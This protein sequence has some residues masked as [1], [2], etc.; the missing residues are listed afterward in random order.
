LNSDSLTSADKWD[1]RYREASGPGNPAPILAEHLHLLPAGGNALD[2]ACGLG[3]NTLLLAQHGLSTQGWD[4]SAVALQRLNERAA[5][6]GLTVTTRQRDVEADPPPPRSF[7]LIVVTDFL[8]RPICPAISAALR[9]GGLLFYSTWCAGKRSASGP[10]NPEFL[11]Q[12][13]EL[14]RLFPSLHVRFYREDAAAGT[15]TLGDRDRAHLIAQ[16]PA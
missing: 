6:Q 9:P 5:D 13:N 4:I 14:L 15:L 8:F 7:D 11:L 3:A 1:R 12:P 10:S 2:L 16:Q